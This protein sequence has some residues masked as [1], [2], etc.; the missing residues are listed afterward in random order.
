MRVVVVELLHVEEEGKGC[1][2]L[3][4]KVDTNLVLA[5]LDVNG[6]GVVIPLLVE[7]PTRGERGTV[8]GTNLGVIVLTQAG[9]TIERLNVRATMLEVA[10]ALLHENVV[11]GQCTRTDQS[12]DK[13]ASARKKTHLIK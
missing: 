4:V 2:L 6:V 13:Y 8:C 3:R 5:V 9:V 10:N 11:L 1:R 7:F 12:S